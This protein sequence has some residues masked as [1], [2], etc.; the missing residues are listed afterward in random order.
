MAGIEPRG[1]GIMDEGVPN[2]LGPGW[3]GVCRTILLSVGCTLLPNGMILSNAD[4][5][6]A[7]DFVAG[8][9]HDWFE[10][11]PALNVGPHETPAVELTVLG[12][13]VDPVPTPTDGGSAEEFSR[14]EERSRTDD[15]VTADAADEVTDEDIC[16][17]G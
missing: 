1:C 10:V 6:G 12:N 17:G 16:N 9:F 11:V 14:V 8:L 15:F 5:S 7:D 13:M 2:G 4:M 3:A